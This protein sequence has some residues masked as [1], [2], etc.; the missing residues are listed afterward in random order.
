M[1][2]NVKANHLGIFGSTGSGKSSYAK[3]VLKSRKRVIVF[4]PQDEYAEH[5]LTRV[6]SVDGV[7]AAFAKNYAGARVCFVPPTADHQP[8]LNR[9]CAWVRDYLQGNKTG[10]ATPLPQARFKKNGLKITLLVEEMN[11]TFPVHAGAISGCPHFADLCSRGRQ[12]GV[13]L[14]GVSQRMAEVNMRFRGNCT[15][16][17]GFRQK[18]AKDRAALMDETGVSMS[19]LQGLKNLEFVRES[20]GDMFTGCIKF[21]TAGKMSLTEKKA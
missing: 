9:L 19:V 2:V 15:E 20:S 16:T 3:H 17:I 5:G 4:D 12:I 6:T 7:R 13:E 21:S 11:T 1:A 10:T 18:A 8:H 14:I